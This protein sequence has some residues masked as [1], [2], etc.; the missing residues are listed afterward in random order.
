M[1][2]F[3]KKL[4]CGHYFARNLM[5]HHL[6]LAPLRHMIMSCHEDF[7][8]LRKSH[9]VIEIR[10]TRIASVFQIRNV[11]NGKP[12]QFA[13]IFCVGESCK[14]LVS[15]QIPYASIF[16][17]GESTQRDDLLAEA[18]ACGRGGSKWN[19]LE[20]AHRANSR[21]FLIRL[22]YAIRPGALYAEQAPDG[23]RILFCLVW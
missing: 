15:T 3:L 2:A 12:T 6:K 5:S 22:L 8:L 1:T 14:G 10:N 19:V 13:S 11:M 20:L 17:A 4:P 7:L 16:Y 18:W 21:T 9:N 23:R